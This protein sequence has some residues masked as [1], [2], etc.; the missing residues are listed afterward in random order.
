[1]NDQSSSAVMVFYLLNKGII[2]HLRFDWQ[3]GT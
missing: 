3:Q 2:N 1:M